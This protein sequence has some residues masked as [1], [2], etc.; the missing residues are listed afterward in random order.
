MTSKG[1]LSAFS[2]STKQAKENKREDQSE[3]ISNKGDAQ[4]IKSKRP[5]QTGVKD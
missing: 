2:S 5:N 1:V 4:F 3:T